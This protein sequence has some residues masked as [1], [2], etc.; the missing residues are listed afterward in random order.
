MTGDASDEAIPQAAADGSDDDGNR[1][2]V[3]GL[4]DSDPEDAFD[5]ADPPPG[6]KPKGG[7]LLTNLA[8]ILRGA[9]LDVHEVDGWQQRQRGGSGYDPTPIGII[10]HHTA[11]P[12][13]W[14]GQRDVNYLALECDVKP[15]S[16]LYLARSGAWWVLAAGAS[17]TNGTGGPWGPIPVDS[18]NSRVIGIEAGNNGIG[19]P[20]PDVMQTSYITGVAALADAFDIDPAPRLTRTAPRRAWGADR[21]TTESG[22][23]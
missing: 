20:W 22:R 2:A 5:A 7:Q 12:S 8:S 10:V 19:E 9:G 18:A 11:S 23:R 21:G 1:V 17:N 13:S 15:M 6:T 4:A 14:D 3:D 16:N